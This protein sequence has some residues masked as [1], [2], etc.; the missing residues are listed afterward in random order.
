MRLVLI[1]PHTF[2]FG[3]TLYL[4]LLREHKH[5]LKY[6][7]FQSYLKDEDKEV[8]ILV[9]GLRSSLKLVFPILPKFF[10]ILELYLWLILNG[11]KP[12]RIK[13][14]LDVKKLDPEQDILFGFARSIS[15]L[16][17]QRMPLLPF[18]RFQG[19]VLL[20]FTH[21]FRNTEKLADYVKKIPHL[22][23][24]SEGNL[25]DNPFFKHH[26]PDHPQVYQLPFTFSQ[27]FEVRQPHFS[28]RRN[29]CLALGTLFPVKDKSF[30]DFYGTGQV[31]HPMRRTIFQH[32]NEHS[33]EIDCYM[34]EFHDLK[35]LKSSRPK[36]SPITKTAKKFL[37]YFLLEKLYP[38]PQNDYFK[39]DIVDKYNQY[40][41]FV[42]PEEIIGLPSINIFE[43]MACQCAYLGSNSSLYAKLG[44]KPG[45]HYIAYQENSLPDLI[46][47][48]RYYQQH[49]QE[50][51]RIAL[52]GYKFVHDNF[53]KNKVAAHFWKDLTSIS[54]HFSE[55]SE[56]APL[57]SFTEQST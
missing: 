45:I 53:S 17:P 56:I 48:I 43:G 23:I 3:N 28:S 7:Y 50:L 49:P 26:F 25:A 33:A 38:L 34:R 42:C 52:Q 20:H 12:W 37:P 40:K 30:I 29:K 6:D 10:S 35:E 22:L 51:A 54:N 11:L 15:E 27:R 21:Y 46:A 4:F 24:V 57:C 5:S 1:N 39:F 36:D 41:M 32:Q 13:I 2:A 44:M 19:I 14:Y 18:H 31:L 9:D 16:E 47:K 8:A 55:H